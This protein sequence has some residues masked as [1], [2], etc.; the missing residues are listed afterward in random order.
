MTLTYVV[1]VV[2][3]ICDSYRTIHEG[4][5]EDFVNLEFSAPN[6]MRTS[7]DVDLT[8]YEVASVVVN[9]EIGLVVIYAHR[10]GGV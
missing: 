5:T 6:D 10:K 8:K 3:S 2:D 7:D 4:T 9:A 1:R